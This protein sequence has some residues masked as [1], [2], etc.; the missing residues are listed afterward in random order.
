MFDWLK[1]L[2]GE[3]YIY[4]DIVCDDG[5]TGR[6]KAPYIGDPSTFDRNEYVEKLKAEVWHK[7]GRRVVEVNNLRIL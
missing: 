3:G 7:H 5:S 1:K 2:Y 6:A 4:A